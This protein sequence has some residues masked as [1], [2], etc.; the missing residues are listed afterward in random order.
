MNLKH[1]N[2]SRF[3]I[4]VGLLVLVCIALEG[5]ARSDDFEFGFVGGMGGIGT[6][7]GYGIAV[8][9]FGNAYTTGFFS[10]TA[11]FDPGVDTSTLTSVGGY[12]IFVQKLDAAGDLVWAKSMGGTGDDRGRD[13]AV[14]S[15]GNVYTTGFF[16]GSGDFDPGAGESILT[17]AGEN[18]IFVSKLDT[19]GNLLWAASF[20]DIESDEGRGIAVDASGNVYV[21]GYF[22]GTVDFDPGAGAFLVTSVGSRDIFVLKLDTAGNFLWVKT[23]GGPSYETA[24]AIT[25]DASGNIYLTGYFNDTVD[26]DPGA[27]TV[28]L[29]SAGDLEAFVCKLDSDGDF[30]WAKAMGG[31]ELDYGRAIAVDGPGNVY[32]TGLFVGT[33]D[34]D[35]G[36]GTAMLTSAGGYDIFVLKLDSDGT[37]VWA[38][39]FGAV[40]EDYGN[41]IAVNASD[42]VYLTGTFTDTV[43]FDPSMDVADLTSAGSY[44]IFLQKLDSNG[45][46]IWATAM[47]ADL[48][49]FG[50]DL[51]LGTSG[52]VYITGY[53]RKTVRFD[54]DMVAADVVSAGLTDVFVLQYIDPSGSG[55]SLG[56]CLIEHVTSGTG[57]A[58]DLDSIRT[59][60]DGQLL[61]NSFGSV[62]AESY[63]RMSPDAVKW[64]DSKEKI[65][66]EFVLAFIGI[67][68]SKV[69]VGL[70]RRWSAAH[71]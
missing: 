32:T 7:Y 69:L 39:R 68:I 70:V 37:F 49:D 58:H 35:P 55:S 1:Q 21:T 54:P 31:A 22:D 33:A 14:D 62:L 30:L 10:I 44:E 4:V 29:T 56:P 65:L 13:I 42:H 24:R 64:I 71:L 38:N 25:V 51:A 15:S 27:G 17:L 45:G 5:F 41:G 36:A 63:Y 34:F 60:R 28:N 6:D 53:F 43:D 57:L 18:D 23:M 20:G 48:D 52:R 8:D 26:F 67:I 47:G 16:S 3:R 66:R 9:E 2:Q 50:F 40:N 61:A 19:N 12:E 59:F 11:D 46:L